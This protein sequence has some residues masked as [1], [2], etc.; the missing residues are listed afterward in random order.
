MERLFDKLTE[1]QKWFI[2]YKI[3]GLTDKKIMKKLEVP[4]AILREMKG[5]VRWQINQAFAE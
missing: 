3:D 5:E 2:F 4:V 1:A